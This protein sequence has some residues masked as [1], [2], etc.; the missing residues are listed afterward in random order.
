MTL[1]DKAEYLEGIKRKRGEAAYH[2]L[3]NE[4]LAQKK[5]IK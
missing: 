1:R 3:R 2:L 5:A 4:M